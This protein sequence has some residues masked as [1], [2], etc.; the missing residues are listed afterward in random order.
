MEMILL[1]ILNLSEVKVVQTVF[2]YS[3]ICYSS[4]HIRLALTEFNKNRVFIGIVCGY[5]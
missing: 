1:D 5:S 3:V 2:Q 4:K